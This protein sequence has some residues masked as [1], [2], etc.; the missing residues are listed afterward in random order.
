MR[1][2]LMASQN[3]EKLGCPSLL[4]TTQLYPSRVSFDGRVNHVSPGWE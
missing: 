3:W 4:E 2:G 1:W